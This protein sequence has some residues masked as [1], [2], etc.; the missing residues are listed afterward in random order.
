MMDV[1]ARLTT[2]TS[3]FMSTAFKPEWLLYLLMFRP[4]IC[5]YSRCLCLSWKVQLAFQLLRSMLL[6]DT[7]LDRECGFI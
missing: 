1:R 4:F 7:R 5:R 3:L 6:L 2:A